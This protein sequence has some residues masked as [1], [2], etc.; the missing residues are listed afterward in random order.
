MMPLVA[1]CGRATWKQ[2][3]CKITA[4]VGIVGKEVLRVT[5]RGPELLVILLVE[6]IYGLLTK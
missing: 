3:Y 1:F 4:C 6:P 5:P 2:R